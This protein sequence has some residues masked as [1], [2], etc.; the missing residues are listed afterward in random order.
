MIKNIGNKLYK[1]SLIKSNSIEIRKAKYLGYGVFA[2][3]D[4]DEGTVIEECVVAKDILP[5]TN[6]ALSNYRFAGEGHDVIILGNASVLGH[7]K[8]PNCHIVQNMDYERVVR[9][10]ALRRILTNEELTHTYNDEYET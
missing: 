3:K 8:T 2:T 6:H 1:Y 4:I 9:I 5:R 10:V 7:S